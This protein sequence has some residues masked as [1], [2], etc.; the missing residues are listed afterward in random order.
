MNALWLV[1]QNKAKMLDFFI[2]HLALIKEVIS[3]CFDHINPT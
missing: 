3:Q 2:D 1:A